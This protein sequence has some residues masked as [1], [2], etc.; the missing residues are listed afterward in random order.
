MTIEDVKND[1]E[2]YIYIYNHERICSSIGCYFLMN[3]ILKI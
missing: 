1:V 3:I 2:D